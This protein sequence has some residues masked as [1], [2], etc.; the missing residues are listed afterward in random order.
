[1][2]VR[3]GPDDYYYLPS[4]IGKKPELGNAQKHFLTQSRAEAKLRSRFVHGEEDLLLPA[5]P[6]FAGLFANFLCCPP[7][8]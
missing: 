5:Y 2:S 3:K 7:P 8:E 4:Q 6:E 1:V